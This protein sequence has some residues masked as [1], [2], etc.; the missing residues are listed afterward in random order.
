MDS[1]VFGIQRNLF[2]VSWAWIAQGCEMGLEV[3]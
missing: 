1:P 2:G 3:F